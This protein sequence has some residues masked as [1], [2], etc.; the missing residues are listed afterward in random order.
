M[1]NTST[2]ECNNATSVDVF[3]YFLK[4]TMP[5]N[6]LL[7]SKVHLDAGTLKYIKQDLYVQVKMFHVA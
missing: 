4:K 7:F 1:M 3:I 6:N 5:L 2:P